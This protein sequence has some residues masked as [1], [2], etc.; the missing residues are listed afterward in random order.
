MPPGQDE[1]AEGTSDPGRDR[2]LSESG[3][4]DVVFHGLGA[5]RPWDLGPGPKDLRRSK[6]RGG[7]RAA[8]Y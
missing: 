6:P 3:P 7:F 2:I 4:G 5:F 1:P 8:N